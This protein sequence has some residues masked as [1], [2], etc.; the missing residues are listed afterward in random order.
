MKDFFER[1]N[2]LGKPKRNDI[3]EKDYH[4]HRLLHQISLNDHLSSNLVFKGGTCLMKAYT[5]YYRFSED[6]DFTWLD[7]NIWEGRNKSEIVRLCSAE[8]DTLAKHFRDIS[9]DLGLNFSGDKTNTDEVNISSGGRVVQFFI[10]YNSEILNMASRIKVEINFMDITLYAFKKKN[11]KSYVEGIDSEEM[12]FLYETQ[13]KEYLTPVTLGCYDSREI[14]I[15]KCRALMTR[16]AYKLRDVIDIYFLEKNNNYSIPA[17]KKAIKRKTG[18]MLELYERYRENIKALEL[19]STNILAS[20]E[21]KLLLVKPPENL[22]E[23]VN[24]IHG[25]LDKI[26]EELL[27]NL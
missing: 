27:D 20:E 5:G 12:E 22:E 25:Q 26:R 6:V 24:R 7:K 14:F 17:Y 1:L 4:L 3:I 19:P 23:N 8:I 9:N 2:A 21:M 11:L 18:F 16:K 10:G 13:W 15:E